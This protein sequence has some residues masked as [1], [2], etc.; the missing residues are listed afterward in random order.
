MRYR[1]RHDEIAFRRQRYLAIFLLLVDVFTAFLS[2]VVAYSAHWHPLT[3]DR[4][5]LTGILAGVTVVLLM[6]AA[7]VVGGARDMW[8]SVASQA[9]I[10]KRRDSDFFAQ[11]RMIFFYAGVNLNIV[12]LA[13][14]I[15]QTGGITASPYTTVFFA[16][17]LTG[18]QLSRFKTQSSFLISV[19]V[20]LTLAMWIFESANGPL[21]APGPPRVLTFLLMASVFIACGLI[22]NYEKN[23]N[24]LIESNQSLPT[25]AHIYKDGNNLWHYVIY[26]HRYRLDPVL[27]AD[28]SPVPGGDANASLDTIRTRVE[29]DVKSMYQAAGWGQPQ[30]NWEEEGTKNEL[31][32]YFPP[33]SAGTASN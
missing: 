29:A 26:R 4:A 27:G 14:L 12:V 30:F 13:I 11:K 20:A 17:V 10:E 15:E 3:R 33:N 6:L 24:Y 5:I 9:A 7:G 8:D 25:H 28:P 19:G 22:T 2:I 31:L 1:S 23:H 32:V 16:L 18:Q 21:A